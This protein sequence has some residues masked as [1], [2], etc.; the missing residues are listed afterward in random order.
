MVLNPL[1]EDSAPSLNLDLQPAPTRH[2][3][4]DICGPLVQQLAEW[5]RTSSPIGPPESARH[6]ILETMTS[7]SISADK[8]LLVQGAVVLPWKGCKDCICSRSGEFSE[9]FTSVSVMD[10]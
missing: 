10:A 8:T 1:L 4:P 6:D 5:M 9:R 2:M 7:L 3:Q